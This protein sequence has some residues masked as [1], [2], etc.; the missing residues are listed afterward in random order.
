MKGRGWKPIEIV[1]LSCVQTAEGVMKETLQALLDEGV[2]TPEYA[3]AQA[4]A[5]TSALSRA[6]V[7]NADG[8]GRHAEAA[9]GVAGWEGS[10]GGVC[11]RAGG[12]GRAAP[13]PRVPARLLQS[14]ARRP[15]VP[16]FLHEQQSH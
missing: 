8:G 11:W 14:A 5:H 6:L 13:P 10:D 9:A 15:Q 3:G 2:L 7:G 16:A 4:V 1:L 12:G